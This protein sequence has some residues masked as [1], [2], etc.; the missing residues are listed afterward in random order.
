MKSPHDVLDKHQSSAAKV[1]TKALLLIGYS[2]APKRREMWRNC[3]I[4]RGNPMMSTPG[5]RRSSTVI[6]VSLTKFFTLS[7]FSGAY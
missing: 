7:H 1:S 3:P 2:R 6:E 4:A 5:T